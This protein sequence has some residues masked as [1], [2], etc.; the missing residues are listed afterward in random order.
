MLSHDDA[1]AESSKIELV[2]CDGEGDEKYSSEAATRQ[3]AMGIGDIDVMV[4][5]A[6]TD[7]PYMGYYDTNAVASHDNSSHDAEQA[8]LLLTIDD[9]MQSLAIA[10]AAPCTPQWWPIKLLVDNAARLSAFIAYFV[11]LLCGEVILGLYLTAFSFHDQFRPIESTVRT[12]DESGVRIQHVTIYPYLN[13]SLSCDD[14]LIMNCDG[15][16]SLG[17]ELPNSK[18]LFQLL[19]ATADSWYLYGALGFVAVV[20]GITALL[21]YEIYRARQSA[22]ARM[23]QVNQGCLINGLS[24]SLLHLANF[25]VV[26]V[27]GG[28]SASH[29]MLDVFLC[30]RELCGLP[31]DTIFKH[32]AEGSLPSMLFLLFSISFLCLNVVMAIVGRYLH[33]RLAALS[34]RSEIDTAHD[35]ELMEMEAGAAAVVEDTMLERLEAIDFN[36]EKVPPQFISLISHAIMTHPVTTDCVPADDEADQ[37]SFEAGELERSFAGRYE[38]WQEPVCPYCNKA[39]EVE[40]SYAPNPELKAKIEAFVAEKEAEYEKAK[41]AEQKAKNK[42]RQARVM[43]KMA[44]KQ[45]AFAK[46]ACGEVQKPSS[47]SAG[48]SESSSLRPKG[49]GSLFQVQVSPHQVPWVQSARED[50][51]TDKMKKRRMSL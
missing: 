36:F 26:A 25:I 10:S 24:Q 31:G 11:F 22:V 28:Y 27:F 3:H 2:D 32:D 4:E 21:T 42:E 49:D 8:A 39:L 5:P 38:L 18:K 16:E 46:K 9:S 12:P 51:I 23:T 20:S 33:G 47:P 1:N 15:L 41:I 14:T 19:L 48:S 29:N 30:N 45:R 43:A 40:K 50:D 44:E 7:S 37:H 17:D 13:R 34:L 6:G 35:T